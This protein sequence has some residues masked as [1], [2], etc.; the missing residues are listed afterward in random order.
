MSLMQFTKG[1]LCMSWNEKWPHAW[2]FQSYCNMRQSF[3]SVKFVPSKSSYSLETLYRRHRSLNLP[4]GSL[5]SQQPLQ[6]QYEPDVKVCYAKI[7]RLNFLLRNRAHL[8]TLIKNIVDKKKQATNRSGTDDKKHTEGE[9]GRGSH[10]VGREENK[11]QMH[12][13]N[14]N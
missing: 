2:F 9:E 13:Y 12:T 3:P 10:H 11:V 6:Q 14:K 7:L 1:M 4:R 8:G 5:F